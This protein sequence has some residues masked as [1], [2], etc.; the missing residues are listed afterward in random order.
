MK[1]LHIRA[2]L[3]AAI[4]VP[5]AFASIKCD[6]KQSFCEVNA[7]RMV[8]GDE[9]VFV[10]TDQ[11]IV[12]YG[13]VVGIDDMTRRIDITKK[14]GDI[15]AD[16]RVVR[17]EIFAAT[18]PDMKT[19]RSPSKMSLGGSFGLSPMNVAS[20]ATAYNAEAFG[21]Y[22]LSN[23]Y[24]TARMNYFTASGIVDTGEQRSEQGDYAISGIGMLGGFA[25]K[26]L[27]KRSVGGRISAEAGLLYSETSITTQTYP[28]NLDKVGSG[29]GFAVRGGIDMVYQGFGKLQPMASGAV[30]QYNRARVGTLSFGIMMDLQ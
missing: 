12:A 1:K 15:S 11:E 30:S 27:P 22:R 3:L 8:I 18:R 17:K 6:R 26:L 24:A 10:N 23:L 19:F 25:Y 28:S 13:E 14:F 7:K 9:V 2:V 5:Q 29:V 4:L 20:D 16:D 21:Q